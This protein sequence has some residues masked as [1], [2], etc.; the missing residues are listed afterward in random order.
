MV[1]GE[2][3]SGGALALGVG[4]RLLMLEH[5]TYSVISPEGC[6]TILFRDAG[7][8]AEAARALRLTAHDLLGYGVVDEVVA[9]PPGGAHTDH[10]AAAGAVRSALRRHLAELRDVPVDDLVERR[11]RRLRTADGYPGG[12]PRP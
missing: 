5:S 1:V 10:D 4:D 11:H 8:A 9:E 7:R 3:G 6:A 2:G 12:A